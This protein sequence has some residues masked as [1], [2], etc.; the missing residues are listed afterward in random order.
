[1]AQPLRHAKTCPLLPPPGRRF[2]V[3]FD[4]KRCG[5]GQSVEGAGARLLRARREERSP[6]RG[7]RHW[8]RY[9]LRLRPVVDG[10]R[11]AGRQGRV[12]PRRAGMVRAWGWQEKGSVKRAAE[13][14]E[15]TVF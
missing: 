8:S 12:C 15:I 14:G 4:R 2:L 1:M 7:V 5:M 3:F 6:N 11:F 9:G 10:R 13:N